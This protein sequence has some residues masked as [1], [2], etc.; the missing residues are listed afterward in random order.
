MY[1]EIYSKTL[2]EI[3]TLLLSLNRNIYDNDS[4]EIQE[5]AIEDLRKYHKLLEEELVSLEANSDWKT[6]N[7]AFYG[8]TNAGKSTLIETLRILLDESTKKEQRN[9]FFSEKQKWI[10]KVNNIKNISNELELL[11][12]AKE[13]NKSKIEKQQNILIDKKENLEDQLIAKQLIFG[14]YNNRILSTM[15]DGFAG[16][17]KVAFKKTKEQKES[18][19]L[20]EEIESI[21]NDLSF[22]NQ[23]INEIDEEIEVNR[24]EI[25]E[26]TA[27]LNKQRDLLNSEISSIENNLTRLSDGEIIGAQTDFTR[28]VAAYSFQSNGI[29]Y[30]ILDLPGIEGKE[31]LVRNEIKKAVEKAHCVLYISR[32]P[33]SPQKGDSEHKGT[34]E[35]ISEHL[36][37]QSEVYFIYNKS[38]RNP[39]QL[40]DELETQ[41]IVIG[42]NEVDKRML[43]TIPDNYI[44]HKT[45]SAYPAF[46][47]ISNSF[48]DSY[49]KSKDKFINEFSAEEILLK[50]GIVAFKEWIVNELINNYKDKI[51]KSNIKKIRN[52]NINVMNLVSGYKLEFIEFR[53][54]IANDV[55]SVEEQLKEQAEIFTNDINNLLKK[56]KRNLEY[57]SRQEIYKL[58]EKGVGNNDLTN[59]F[60]KLLMNNETTFENNIQTGTSEISNEFN[61][62]V[63]DIIN[64]HCN[65]VEELLKIRKN[66]KFKLDYSFQIKTKAKTN[67]I[68]ALLPIATF[69]ITLIFSP[70]HGVVPLIAA[71]ISALVSFAKEIYGLFDKSYKMEQQKKSVNEQLVKFSKELEN[72]IEQIRKELNDEINEIIESIIKELQKTENKISIIIQAFQDV[73]NT[74][75]KQIE[76]ID[77]KEEELYG[78]N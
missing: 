48:N 45:V 55:N 5:H 50:S 16:F 29:E 17:I 32:K 37:G 74:L 34:I 9:I 4:R 64:G 24:K 20:K 58:I 11:E 28:K 43:E 46:I 2:H 22:V 63:A 71:G 51:I 8:E 23:S 61:H 59:S 62:E 6:F 41:D 35:K 57:S 72:K 47:S 1:S 27:S 31:E 52:A 15:L 66:K 21:L 70:D 7:I 44:G 25:F 30:K 13:N 49:V 39:N 68:K 26:K 38:I 42:L 40:K 56:E 54:E 53:N 67:M 14:E 12:K 69:I 3:D 36:S 73:Q 19:K 10:E 33:K 76:W 78:N 60:K 75:E 18:Q 77:G 65:Y